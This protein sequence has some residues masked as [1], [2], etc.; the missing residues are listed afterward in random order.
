MN[1]EDL[2]KGF[3][4]F[5]AGCDYER[6]RIEMELLKFLVYQCNLKDCNCVKV[7]DFI[8]H[9]KQLDEMEG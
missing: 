1:K 2:A 7:K 6:N 4:T 9:L 8:E 5:Q 3:A